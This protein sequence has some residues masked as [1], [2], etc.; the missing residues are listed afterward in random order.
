MEINEYIREDIELTINEYSGLLFKSCFLILKN[1]QDAEDVVQETFY[2]Y[3][4][5]SKIFA[6]KE[7]KKA[8]LLRVSY[9]IC[10]NMIRF[11]TMHAHVS[12]DEVERYIVNKSNTTNEDILDLI[13]VSNMSY[14]NKCVVILHYFEGY[15]IDETASIL[16]ITPSAV[17]K[18]L[19]RARTKLKKTYE[20]VSQ[21]GASGYGN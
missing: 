15:S 18:R 17:K 8:W 5:N 13:E 9:N 19:Q 11:K 2:K 20:E 16:D 1:K 7:H 21:K 12:F 3:I 6:S 4:T 14:E 10:K